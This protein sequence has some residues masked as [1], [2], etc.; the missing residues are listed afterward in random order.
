MDNEASGAE[1]IRVRVA[2]DWKCRAPGTNGGASARNGLDKTHRPKTRELA[3]GGDAALEALSR[4]TASVEGHGSHRG[5][6]RRCGGIYMG[7]RGTGNTTEKLLAAAELARPHREA[8]A[9]SRTRPPRADRQL[10]SP[11]THLHLGLHERYTVPR[12]EASAEHSPGLPPRCVG[13]AVRRH[14]GPLS[15]G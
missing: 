9:T 12:L 3:T 14:A 8:R 1:P 5:A 4:S 15:S 2:L 13:C 6:A 10:C 11:P 7:T